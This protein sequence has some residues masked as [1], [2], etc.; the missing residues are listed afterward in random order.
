MRNLIVRAASAD[1]G[2]NAALERRKS[3]ACIHI[4]L[5]AQRDSWLDEDALYVAWNAIAGE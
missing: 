5:L 3:C 2:P 1:D 4:G